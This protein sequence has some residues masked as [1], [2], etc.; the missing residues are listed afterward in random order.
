MRD[1][2]KK[3]VAWYKTHRDLLE[4]DVLHLRRADG[5][6]EVAKGLE[7]G[8]RDRAMADGSLA[9]IQIV[10]E[11]LAD[12]VDATLE[13]LESRAVELAA[14]GDHALAGEAA[15]AALWLR[16]GFAHGPSD[17]PVICDLVG[18]RASPLVS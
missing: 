1:M 7:S 6:F 10:D 16:A 8:S 17:D 13:V 18:G 5:R 12:V 11:W 14:A 15:S 4:S 9:A 2:V 3:N